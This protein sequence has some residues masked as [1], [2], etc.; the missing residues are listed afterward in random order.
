[1]TATQGRHTAP[2]AVGGLALLA[3]VS[4]LGNGFVYDDVPII[5]QNPLVHDLGR[6][7]D[8]WASAY[9]PAG[10]AYRPLT[11]QLF[12]LVWAAGGGHPFAFHL[13][14]VALAIATAVLV[15]KLARLVLSPVPAALAAALFAVHPAHVEV[16]ANAVGQAELL[17]ALFGLVAVERYIVWRGTGALT[18]SHRVILALLTALAIHAKETGYAIPLLLVAAEMLL[19]RPKHAD[20]WRWREAGPGLILQLCVAIASVLLRISVIGPTTGAGPL[21]ALT[22]LTTTE[23]LVTM[24]GVVPHWARLLLWP[25]HLQGDYGPPAISVGGALGAPQVAGLILVVATAGLIAASWRR[26]PVAAFGLIWAGMA[27]LPVSNILAPTGVI[28][29][30]RT[31]FLP[32]VGIVLVLGAAVQAVLIRVTRPRVRIVLAGGAAAILALGAARSA[33]RSTVWQNQDRFFSQLVEDAPTTYRAHKVAAKYLTLAGRPR[34]AEVRW[35]RALALY[36][37]DGTVFEELGQ[38]YRADGR[39]GQAIPLFER[40]LRIHPT[41]TTLRARFIECRLKLG[42]TTGA[43]A[44]AREAVELGHPEFEQTIQRLTSM[45]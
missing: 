16:I 34:D 2:L 44:L 28:L 29:A 18:T 10:L 38:L 12:A 40:G 3:A 26:A 30:E 14:N 1:M 23:R 6:S 25:A 37:G 22:D 17:V 21:P 20:S 32:S 19:V 33:A 31:L 41:R 11:V 35:R 9:W 27:I 43:L 4:G 15:W 42:D 13:V 45:R 24:L 39:C 7:A 5:L 8:L 36:E